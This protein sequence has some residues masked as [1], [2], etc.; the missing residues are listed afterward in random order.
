MRAQIITS[1]LP[2]VLCSGRET[3]ETLASYERPI[4][5]TMGRKWESRSSVTARR[6][7]AAQISKESFQRDSVLIGSLDVCLGIYS[8]SVQDCCQD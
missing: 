3:Q 1:G 6:G 4:S 8:Y 7:F 5:E 2:S